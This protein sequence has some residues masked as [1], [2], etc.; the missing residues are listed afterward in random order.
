MTLLDNLSALGFTEYEARVY[1]ALLKEYP[2]TGYQLSKQAGI[3]RSMVYEA[4]G[5]LDVRGAVL[6][7]EEARVTL[8]RPLPPDVLLNRLEQEYARLLDALRRDLNAIYLAQE[9][10]HLWTLRG[11]ERILNYAQ[12]MLAHAEREAMLVL[13]DANLHRLQA[14]LLAAAERGVSIGALLTGE[15]PLEVGITVHHPPHETR[16]HNLTDSL[17]VVIDE[18]EVLIASTQGTEYTA[19]ITANNNMVRI[20]RQFVWME[21]FAHRIFSRLPPEALQQLSAEERAALQAVTGWDEGR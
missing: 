3:P 21:L 9:E 15:A 4:L 13:N 10:E 7:A 1:L 2:A 12:N 17:V 5:R 18:R 8:Y 6:K 14:A 11:E 19:T 16:L 20:S